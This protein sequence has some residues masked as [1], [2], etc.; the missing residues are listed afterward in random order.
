MCGAEVDSFISDS[1]AGSEQE[2]DLLHII[3]IYK[4]LCN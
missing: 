2:E 4:L 3:H 1:S